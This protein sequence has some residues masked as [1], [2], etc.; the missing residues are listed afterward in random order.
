MRYKP[1]I[2]SVFVFFILHHFSFN[3]SSNANPA[4]HQGPGLYAQDVDLVKLKKEEEERKKKTKKSKYVVTNENL[5]KIQ[6]PKKPYSFIKLGEKETE[7]AK[8]AGATAGGETGTNVETEI[9]GNTG[10]SS[11]P[12]DTN[13]GLAQSTKEYWQEEVKKLY[14][15]M[16]RTERDIKKSQGELNQVTNMLQAED[17]Y[18]RR[19]EMQ[20]RSDELKKSIPELKQKLDDLNKAMEDLE[21]RARKLGVPPGWLRVDRPEPSPDQQANQDDK[22]EKG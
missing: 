22:K 7:K 2:L 14:L 17:I 15:E 9:A 18:E 8:E 13:T 11:A 20:K 10:T 19:L 5:D 6:L 4:P 12:V 16:D 21:D 1:I 3:P